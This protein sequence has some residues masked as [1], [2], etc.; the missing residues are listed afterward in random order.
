M[1]AGVLAAAFLFNLGQGALRPALPLYLHHVFGAN[2][3]MVTVIPV[4]FGA[5]KWVASVPAG[6]VLDRLGRRR[7]MVAGLVAVAACDI[8][9][10]AAPGYGAFLAARAAAGVAWAVFATAAL[11]I[12]VDRPDARGRAISLLLTSETL[13]L[14]LGSAGGG[15]LYQA[16]GRTSPFFFEAACMLIA[17]TA[18]GR[19]TPGPDRRSAP[20]P[21]GPWRSLGA[22]VQAPSVGLMSVTNAVL[23][24]V[25]TGVL[26]FLFPLYLAERGRLRPAAVGHLV[27]LGVLGRLLALW[28]AGRVSDRG[29]RLQQLGFGLLGYGVLLGT[30]ALVTDPLPLGCWSLLIGAGAGFVAGLP[31]AVIGDHVPG[32]LHA[33]AMGWLRLVTDTGMLVGPLA[34]GALADGVDLTAPFLGAALSLG[35]L[36]GWCHWHRAV[37]R[38]AGGR[39]PW[40]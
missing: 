23:T 27:S 22:I 33:L 15:W 10:A 11:T 3:R 2:Y 37:A 7:L 12:M 24:A 14:L 40:A 35:V 6:Y 21:A 18:A 16:L 1:P 13:G 20:A 30:L 28:V 39:R 31:T 32:P 9:S 36:A 4:V 34:A 19:G 38:P 26:V 5:G 17:A 25:Q 29:D 8:A